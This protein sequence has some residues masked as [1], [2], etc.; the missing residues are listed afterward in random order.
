[1]KNRKNTVSKFRIAL[2]TAICAVTVTSAAVLTQAVFRTDD[3]QTANTVFNEQTVGEAV[4]LTDAIAEVEKQEAAEAEKAAQAAA[5]E[6]AKQTTQQE[7]DG[8]TFTVHQELP[9]VQPSLSPEQAQDVSI[10]VDKSDH[11]LTV[12]NGE[13]VIAQY[14][15]GLGSASAEGAK[16]KEGDKRTPEGEYYICV[17]NNQSKYYLSLGLSY[18]NANDAARGLESGLITQ[19]QYDDIMAALAAGD[20]PDWYTPLGGQIMIH[21][22]MGNLGGQTDWTTGCV[23][24]NNQV[25]DILWKYCK[26]GTKVTILP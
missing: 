15:V 6:R 13:S 5:A 18:P 24:V 25:M 3:T 1:M 8:R 12:Y 9:I 16:Q 10:V 4:D 19:Q 17:L 21:G 11:L 7:I 23:A 20:I 26:V 14:S 22:Q 2:L